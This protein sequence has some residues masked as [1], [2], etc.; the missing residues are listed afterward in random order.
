MPTFV[1]K[2]IDYRSTEGTF[3]MCRLR[4]YVIKAGSSLMTPDI[5]DTTVFQIND[6]RVLEPK[7]NE[8]VYMTAGDRLFPM[9][10]VIDPS[11]ALTIRMREKAALE[12]SWQ[13]S[14]EEFAD[15]TS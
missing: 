8:N 7:A 9:V 12:L 14:K 15:L 5:T 4:D 3:T 6:A 1:K 11:G 13:S 2:E 10:S